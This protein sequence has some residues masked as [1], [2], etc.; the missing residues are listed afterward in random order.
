MAQPG[1]GG[2]GLKKPSTVKNFKK[3]IIVL[4]AYNAATTLKTTIQDI[5]QGC[6]DELILVDDCSEDNTVEIAEQL[7]LTV[8]R[9]KVNRGYGANQKSCYDAALE[10]GADVIVMLHPDYQ[11]DARLISHFIGF[12][13]TGVCDVMLGSRIRTRAEALASG[14]PLYKYISNRAL[15]IAENLALGQN[16]GD[17][18]SGFRCYRREVLETIPYHSNS[19]D[20][21]FDSQFLAQAAYFGFRIG[22]APV[23]CRYFREASSINFCRSTKYGILT[24]WTLVQFGLQK[25]KLV[26]FKIFEQK[27]SDAPHKK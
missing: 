3:L 21:V 15:T 10:R 20:F 19:N 9:H 26:K 1:C 18:H 22:D 4:P 17:F 6:F 23:P 13:E 16:L 14:M 5:P 24:L 12:M 7:G 27:D 2:N 25:S 11:Y 8:I